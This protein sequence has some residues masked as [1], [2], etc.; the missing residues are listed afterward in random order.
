VTIPTSV[1]SVL[2]A[3]IDRLSAG[4]KEVLQ[5]A[6]VVGREFTRPV[7]QVAAG[8]TDEEL[9][10]ALD[11]LTEAELVLRAAEGPTYRIKH[12]LAE[13]VAYRSQL[14]R[15]RVKIHAAVAAAI[16]QLNPERLG[17]LA[18]LI[19]HHLIEAGEKAQAAQWCSRA[20]AWSG[21]NDPD[22]ALRGPSRP[23]SRSARG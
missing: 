19:A 16:E 10:A 8:I 14:E 18:A 1:E 20:A 4:A 7:L 22:E 6:A 5:V 21:F 11:E 2:T 17:E 9:G 3:R 13:Q 12:A 15:R 23:A